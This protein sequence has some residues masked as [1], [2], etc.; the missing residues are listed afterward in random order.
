MKRLL[1][2]F[3]V[4]ILTMSNFNIVISEE[5]ECEHVFDKRTCIICGYKKPPGE[6]FGKAEG[7][8][9][10]PVQTTTPGVFVGSAEGTIPPSNNSWEYDDIGSTPVPAVTFTPKPT[11]TPKPTATNTPRP[12]S[13]PTPTK[14]A[15]QHANTY[16]VKSRDEDEIVGT[17]EC[18]LIK[19]YI[20]MT[21]CENCGKSVASHVE[22]VYSNDHGFDGRECVFCGYELPHKHD[23]YLRT[24]CEYEQYSASRHICYET[25]TTYCIECGEILDTEEYEYR[26][27]HFYYNNGICMF[28]DYWE[29]SEYD[30]DHEYEERLF[31]YDYYYYDKD[32]HVVSMIW[33]EYCIICG[34]VNQT[35]TTNSYLKHNNSNGICADCKESLEEE[36]NTFEETT[37]TAAGTIVLHMNDKTGYSDGAK[38]VWN[39]TPKLVNNK[40]MVPL[41]Q[42]TELL[43]GQLLEW[44]PYS[45]SATILLNGKVFTYTSGEKTIV[46]SNSK[47][48]NSA[49][50]VDNTMYVELTSIVEV[51]DYAVSYYDD[52][53]VVSDGYYSREMVQECATAYYGADFSNKE[54]EV[55]TTDK[56]KAQARIEELEEVI[57]AGAKNAYKQGTID[58]TRRDEII[59]SA[60]ATIKEYEK[61]L[62]GKKQLSEVSEQEK[63]Y[64]AVTG[65]KGAEVEDA[66]EKLITL[67]YTSQ[68]VT[69][70]YDV[71]TF[72]NIAYFQIIND[73]E[74][75]GWLD[76]AT[77]KE[78]ERQYEELVKI[79]IEVPFATLEEITC[80]RDGIVMIHVIGNMCT[81]KLVIEI[82]GL[83]FS[84]KTLIYDCEGWLVTEIPKT[85][86]Y[87]IWATAHSQNGKSYTTPIQNL[88][89]IKYNIIQK[90]IE[91]MAEEKQLGYELQLGMATSIVENQI[92]EPVISIA[93]AL[94]YVYSYPNEQASKTR[95]ESREE[96]VNRIERSIQEALPSDCNY[97]YAG[98]AIGDFINIGIDS[99]LVVNGV[100]A[101]AT[102]VKSLPNGV[103]LVTAKIASA[104]TG[105]Y[106]TIQIVVDGATIQ[107]SAAQITNGMV[108][109]AIA[110]TSSR[111][112]E[113]W[114]DVEDADDN[115][116][117]R[118]SSSK[119]ANNMEK[120]GRNRP[121]DYKTAAHHIVAGNSKKAQ[122]AREILKEFGIGINH[123]ANGVFLPAQ[124]DVIGS[125]YHP[126]L[127]TD[128]YYEKVND[129]LSAA[130]SK[131]EV[132]EILREIA[133]QLTNG[134]F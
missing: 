13:T 70:K 29:E 60:E 111:P 114:K 23:K 25:T 117:E 103:K 99:V 91:D 89:F 50:I 80:D 53:C 84:D 3:L 33:E 63:R 41:K 15:C 43:G 58:K 74:V 83:N 95:K 92:V 129:W 66:Q 108:S 71:T 67:S 59:K 24:S 102:G 16:E 17:D 21:I 6:A 68:E 97:Y 40:T 46:G 45:K 34:E 96:Y 14:T 86:T 126:S 61:V 64:K 77:S 94:D 4:I 18:C 76:S 118:A 112:Q 131:E 48:K 57:I 82:S 90:T 31:D 69:S 116:E 32:S 19:T 106:E 75:T 101:I 5:F 121:R 11:S 51:T 2:T 44:N 119:L 110:V 93:N 122:E 27:E 20:I 35:Y 42:F 72:N 28:C 49:Q 38:L 104:S 78:L 36:E 85:G 26:E 81:Q 105:G 124:K 73:L 134:N 88:E 22:L 62:S 37:S 47:M 123:E 55:A 1:A 113:D 127:H 39:V 56:K 10:P 133:K 125:A 87:N 132:I 107:S 12:I 115:V 65:S 98:Q 100:K 54:P 30:C 109:F 79:Q 8:I 7:T 128:A 52:Y 9:P 120:V 130:T